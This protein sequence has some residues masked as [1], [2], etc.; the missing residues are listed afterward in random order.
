MAVPRNARMIFSGIATLAVAGALAAPACAQAWLPLKGEG[1]IATTYSNMYVRNHVTFDGTK[2]PNGGRIRTNMLLTS[3]D[4]GLTDKFAL[5][6]DLA[7]VASKYIGATPHGPLDTGAYHPT[8]Q[9]AHLELRYNA[10]DKGVVV[11]PFIGTTIPTHEY[12]ARGHSAVGLGFHELLLGVSVGR[13]L[14]RILRDSYVDARYSYAILGRFDDVKVN[15]SNA[16]CEVGWFA[17]RSLALRFISAFQKVHGGIVVAL[18][19]ELDEHQKEFHDRITRTDYI[20]LA[21]GITYL[22]KRSFAIHLAYLTTTYGRNVQ[23]PGGMLVGFTW[24]FSRG[25]ALRPT[26]TNIRQVQT[27]PLA[28]AG[29]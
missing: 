23:A 14:D 18:Q 16:S 2:N 8:F 26:V 29:Y 9:N 25:L 3:F 27:S 6:A 22:V 20:Y 24:N 5:N 1:T 21:G 19:P 7:Y 12:E 4:L 17:T 28:R 13:E 15:R 11:T 10:F